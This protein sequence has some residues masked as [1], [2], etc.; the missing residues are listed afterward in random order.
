VRH[1]EH[2]R[3]P[4]GVSDLDPVGHRARRRGGPEDD[5]DETTALLD[6][7]YVAAPGQDR[8]QAARLGHRA[9]DLPRYG[10]AGYGI[11]GY[12]CS[13]PSLGPGDRRQAAVEDDDPV[14]WS[15]GCQSGGQRHTTEHPAVD[16][17]MG[18][19]AAT[20]VR[21]CRQGNRGEQPGQR[22]ARNQGVGHRAVPVMAW[23]RTV[24]ACGGDGQRDLELTHIVG[25]HVLLDQ[26]AQRTRIEQRARSGGDGAS[27]PAQPGQARRC[28][29]MLGPR[30]EPPGAQLLGPL[31]RW[32]GGQEGGIQRPGRAA[33]HLV[34]DHSGLQQGKDAARLVGAQ[35]AAAAEDQEGTAGG[36]GAV[37]KLPSYGI[38]H[39]NLRTT[40]GEARTLAAARVRDLDVVVGWQP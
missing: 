4:D 21:A 29:E 24:E 15:S 16:V 37:R 6:W 35:S 22:A 19:P 1:D 27:H 17:Q 40:V 30:I 36:L 20:T 23:R 7:R 3:I 38:K 2:P 28:Q 33:E 32:L 34:G 25:R 5:I 13:A 39:V 26:P 11:T 10:R 8:G 18:V 12:G 14:L 9:G 31:H